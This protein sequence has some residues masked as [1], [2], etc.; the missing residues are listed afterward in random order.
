MRKDF[1]RSMN[2][3][4]FTVFVVVIAACSNFSSGQTLKADYQFQGNLLSSVGT[5]PAMSQIGGLN[6]F[7]SDRVDGYAR[8]TMRFPANGGLSVNTTGQISSTAYTVVILF[9]FDT[10]AGGRR[11]IFDAKQGL[12]NPCGLYYSNSR[13]EPEPAG[14]TTVHPNTFVQVVI[15]RDTNG[16][17]R[18]ARDGFLIN[19]AGDTC[20][21]NTDNNLRFFAD[22]S[23]VGNEVSAGN[24]ARIRLYDGSMTGLQMRA[25]DRPANATGGGDQKILFSTTRHN[26][27]EIYSMNSDGT[28][29][30]RLTNNTVADYGA[31]WSHDKSKIIFTRVTANVE[32]LWTMNPDGT[33]EI[34]LTNTVNNDHAA[35][36]KP[37]GSKIV[38]SRCDATFLCDI[39]TMNPDGSNQQPFN[40]AAIPSEDED[41]ASYSPDGS[42]IVYGRINPDPGIPTSGLYTLTETTIMARLTS[43]AL[44]IGDREARY[45]PDGTKISYNRFPDILSNANQN[46]IELYRM[47]ANGSGQTNFTNNAVFDNN[48][49]WTQDST[50]VAF[51]SRRDLADVNEIYTMNAATGGSVV[52]LTFNSAGDNI[53]DYFTTPNPTAGLGDAAFDY[54]GDGRTDISVYRPS[55]GTWWISNSAVRAWGSSTDRIAPA[56]YDGDGSTDIAVFRPAEGNWWVLNS[57]T[58]TVS[59]TQ[60]GQSSDVIVPADY[61]GDGRA[62]RAIYRANDGNWWVLDSTTGIA[63][64]TQL[65]NATDKPVPAKYDAD[66]KADIAVYRPGDG[67]WWMLKSQTGTLSVGQLGLPTDLPVPADYTGDSKADIAIWRPSDGTWWY[68]DSF[69]GTAR[70]VAWGLPTDIPVPGDYDG[71]GITEYAVFRPSGGTWWIRTEV[72]AEPPPLAWGTG[73]D[74]PTPSAYIR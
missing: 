19:L 69:T 33:G 49:I 13:L 63:T 10:I 2:K 67:T 59:V 37:D 17:V 14:V 3:F 20:Y 25:L 55:G 56:D 38:F 58:G 23:V 48:A 26:F 57:E 35:S 31:R 32:Q 8:Q 68:I 65:G 7:E 27:Q 24:V 71:N 40:G 62:D 11:R 44:P 45:S 70:G 39:Y 1:E 21:S 4:K 16:A 28:N 41:F 43:P 36:Y 22:D 50:T 61:T 12:S 73:T 42:R 9:R 46:G 18:I 6:T 54:N 51:H 64:V 15:S 5:A 34:Q 52:R 60:W 29:E 66:A 74:I 47:N 53:S 72:G 30:R